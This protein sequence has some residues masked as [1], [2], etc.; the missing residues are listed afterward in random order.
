MSNVD[1]IEYTKD[2]PPNQIC[3]ICL[4]EV[5]AD[6]IT[7]EGVPN[8]V[9]CKNAHFIHR[10]CYDQMSNNKCPICR[11]DVKYNCLGYH[12]YIKPNRKG[13]KKRSNKKSNKNK[14]TKSTKRAKKNKRT[15]SR[16]NRK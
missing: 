2:K 4:E 3:S 1:E 5:D 11:E 14:R 15:K 8:C 12:G 16:K 7:K 10:S 13:G 6:D 9:T